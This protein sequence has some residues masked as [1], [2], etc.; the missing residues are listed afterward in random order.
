[1]TLIYNY[2]YEK[3]FDV[4][5]SH[6][7]VYIFIN[8]L[9]VIIN[10]N[11]LYFNPIVKYEYSPYSNISYIFWIISY[12]VYFNLSL[13]L[14][15]IKS[16]SNKKL[17][18]IFLVII[19]NNVIISIFPLIHGVYTMGNGDLLTHVGIILDIKKYSHIN[20]SLNFYPILHISGFFISNLLNI[21]YLSFLNYFIIIYNIL[22]PLVFT[23]IYKK[24]SNEVYGTKIIFLI[25]STFYLSNSH[26]VNTITSPYH[27]SIL[28]LPFV[29]Y[30]L[31]K[32]V[33]HDKR[34]I[35]TFLI[36]YIAFL[37]IH[38]LINLLFVL[39]IIL[40]YVSL[41]IKNIQYNIYLILAISLIY[42]IYLFSIQ[43]LWRGNILRFYNYILGNEPILRENL[44]VSYKLYKL[45]LSGIDLLIYFL[46]LYGH[47]LILLTTS[48]LY[49]I[50]KSINNY[51]KNKT[52]YFIIF[53]LLMISFFFFIL[54]IIIPNV[55]NLP[56][57]RFLFILV[58]ISPIFFTLFIKTNNKR[59]IFVIVFIIF[60]Q[61][62]F[63]IYNSPIVKLSNTQVTLM[64]LSGSKWYLSHQNNK[65]K[66][67]GFGG[68]KLTM[69]IITSIIPYKDYLTRYHLIINGPIMLDHFDINYSSRNN[70]LLIVTNYDVIAYEQLYTNLDRINQNDIINLQNN[71]DVLL[72][73]TNNHYNLY[74][75]D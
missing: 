19:F 26:N 42:F 23:L 34:H 31:L 18:Y 16:I 59:I 41:K 57:N 65:Y 69:R 47:Q 70:L 21:A 15:S 74:L 13:F 38:P 61:S 22:S 72:I 35:I 64:D 53:S 36:T 17:Y 75:I 63:L 1:M 66:L 3:I 51:K 52:W 25:S 14:I 43:S 33:D 73:Y 46:K 20:I 32:I 7:D 28:F 40:L 49:I 56:Y 10:I 55:I 11:I 48:F 30:L 8:I 24:I 37:Y 29:L 68:Y 5:L 60:V 58:L 54:S 62:T 4:L 44:D 45:G 12:L 9:L 71:I 2:K 27:T 50:T 6:F 39:A 67:T